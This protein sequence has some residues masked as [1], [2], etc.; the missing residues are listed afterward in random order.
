MSPT[1]RVRFAPSPTGYLHLGGLRTA[2]FNY[3]FARSQGGKIILR[4]EDTDRSRLVEDAVGNIIEVFNWLD[5]EF[6][7]GPHVGGN[8]G[9]YIQSERLNIYHEHIDLL[10]DEGHAYRCFCTADRLDQ[11]R[12]GQIAAGKNPMYDRHCRNL[13]AEESAKRAE[14]ESFVVRLKIPDDETIPFTDGVR[15]LVSFETSVIDD[16]VLLK[17]DG[18]PTY[19]LAN[20]VDDHL[21]EIT[22]V[23]RGEEWLTSTPKHVYLYHCFNWELP[24]FYHLSLLLNKDRSKLSKRQGDVAVE[25][26]RAKG[27][28]PESL[29]NYTALLGWHPSDDQE[30]FTWEELLGKFDLQQASKSGAVFDIDKLVWL[31]KQHINRYDHDGFLEAARDFLPGG[32]DFTGE[33][34]AK[35]V[36][37]LQEG[38][39]TFS[40]I[41]EKLKSFYWNWDSEPEP[42]VKEMLTAESSKKVFEAILQV[43]SEITEWNTDVFKSLL[44]QAGKSAGVKGKDLWMSVR[45]AL[46]GQLHGP[47]MGI[48]VERLSQDKF[49]IF[50]DKA[51]DYQYN[52]FQD[53]HK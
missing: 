32:F 16:Q 12:K 6:D 26:Y 5:L 42:E 48:I 9:P 40:E 53:G 46:T 38:I 45:A 8:S 52:Q 39:D 34:G 31:N 7:E 37:W 50:I 30:F 10:M 14:T 25:D 20:V 1:P 3:L 13:T 2:L 35:I 18:Y 28:L 49:F 33:S 19:H 23:I 47:E 43:Q 44:K 11:M 22:G 15:G 41:A 17:S 4:I 21:M 24:N 36:K 51:L 27:F 29:I